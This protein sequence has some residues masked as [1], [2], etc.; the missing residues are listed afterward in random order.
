MSILLTLA[1]AWRAPRRA[2]L[3]VR[4]RRAAATINI[5]TTPSAPAGTAP[6]EDASFLDEEPQKKDWLAYW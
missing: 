4:T 5:P 6:A 1:A 3:N 2:S